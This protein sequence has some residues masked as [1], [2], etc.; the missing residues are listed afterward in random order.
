M[1][2][3]S[4]SVRRSLLQKAAT[5]KGGKWS[6]RSL[7]AMH[8]PDNLH[9]STAEILLSEVNVRLASQHQKCLKMMDSLGT[10]YEDT[11][12]SANTTSTCAGNSSSNTIIRAVNQPLSLHGFSPKQW[13]DRAQQ[14]E[15]SKNVAL[16]GL[17][18][19]E[20]LHA[21]TF[22]ITEHLLS[23]GRPTLKRFSEAD[24]SLIA[25][26]FEQIRSRHAATVENIADISIELRSSEVIEI[27]YSSGS[28]SASSSTGPRNE[29]S[30]SLVDGFL[31]DRL[32]IQLLCDHYVGINKR[33]PGGGISVSCDFEDVLTDAILESKSICDANFGIVPEVHVLFDIGTR[34][35]NEGRQYNH[36]HNHNHNYNHNHNHNQ[37]ED[38]EEETEMPS[39]SGEWDITL[40]RPWVHHALVELLKNGMTSSVQKASLLP[41]DDDADTDADTDTTPPDLIVR[42]RHTTKNE[43]ND[44]ATSTAGEGSMQKYLVCEVMDQGLGLSEN[45][46]NRAFEFAES[47]SQ[48][49]WDRIDEQQSYAMV[50]APIGSLG[51]GLP[52]SR[53]MMQMF[54]GDIHLECRTQVENIY[55]DET[56][57]TPYSLQ[58][59]CSAS[60][61]LPVEDDIEEL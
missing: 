31:R 29:I 5:R 33:K 47:S 51:V 56:T 38:V 48:Q 15:N 57:E 60:L 8:D 36:N 19:L 59:G 50:R 24:K 52:L 37:L 25:A 53:M 22:S 13:S 30:P 20:I 35:G 42:V 6:L 61:I 40:V 28:N 14:I 41:H 58:V 49:R 4:S 46:I 39:G 3:L 2:K 44:K 10:K 21:D 11:S 26:T 9:S 34:V 55:I 23:N 18:N 1:N 12:P 45:G 7:A 32:G 27:D 17:K 16:K 43:D 54:G